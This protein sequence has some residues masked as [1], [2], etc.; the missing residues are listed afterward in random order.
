MIFLDPHL[1]QPAYHIYASN[2]D[3]KEDIFDN[4]SFHSTNAGRILFSKLDPSVA[5][6]FYIKSLEQLNEF[7]SQIKRVGLT[8]FKKFITE[9]T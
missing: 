9:M 5:I 8:F 7:C 3:I 6:G 4:K 2:N 1:C